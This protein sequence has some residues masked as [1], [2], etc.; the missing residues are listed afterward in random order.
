MNTNEIRTGDVFSETPVY[1]L[2]RKLS[3][4]NFQ[5]I[6]QQT[7]KLVEL[8]SQYVTDLLVTADQ[9]DKEVV[10]GKEDKLWTDAQIKKDNIKGVNVGDVRVPGIRTI[11]ENIGNEVFTVCFTKQPTTLSKTAFNNLVK[12]KVAE[13]IDKIESARRSK[14]SMKSA[15]ENVIQDLIENP[16]LQTQPGEER[17]LRGYKLQFSSRDGKYRCFDCDINDSRF[18]NINTLCWIVVN[19]VKY[20]LE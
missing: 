18:V 19:N 12:G 4:G 8:T 10:V 17:V 3:N 5:M 14:K 1:K 13:A 15:A 7:G 2:N 6:H 16:V 9:Y 20:I 11:F